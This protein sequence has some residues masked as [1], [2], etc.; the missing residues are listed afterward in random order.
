M[1]RTASTIAF[2]PAEDSS[3]AYTNR[4]RALLGVLGTVQGYRLRL[5]LRSFLCGNFK[6]NDLLVVN[7]IENDL[8]DRGTGRV[9]LFGIIKLVLK[10]MLI[11]LSSQRTLFVRH[12]VYPHATCRGSASLARRLVDWYESL[13]DVVI[14]HSGD[15][16]ALKNWRGEAVRS[17]VPHPLYKRGKLEERAR[18]DLPDEYF[19]IFGRIVPYK[20]IELAIERFPADKTLVVAGSVD[21][22]A[23][24][25][26][27]AAMCGPNILFAP[28]YL[29]EQEAQSL[30]RNARGLLVTHA[31]ENVLVS[32][33]FFYALSAQCRV[34]AVQTPFLTW[35]AP[36]LGADVVTLSEDIP[37]LMRTLSND[38]PRSICAESLANIEREFGDAAVLAALSNILQAS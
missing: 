18:F 36:R 24:A 14:T 13:F 22:Q 33:S 20:R 15:N 16:S 3:N 34:Y 38:A 6:R 9:S 25:D 27:L 12:N 19:L 37:G 2:I 10:T 1:G 5:A 17:Y 8:I 4:M 21:D 35:V 30:V 26:K 31:E 29:S 11:K 32:G 28:G 23:Y 7:W